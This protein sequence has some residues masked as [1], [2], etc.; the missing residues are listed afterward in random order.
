[1]KT[2]LVRLIIVLSLLLAN[3]VL[4]QT[5]IP[6]IAETCDHLAAEKIKNSYAE[7]VEAKRLE[8]F[9]TIKKDCI[10]RTENLT[11]MLKRETERAA[12]PKTK[13][14][15]AKGA[16]FVPGAIICQDYETVQLMYDWYVRVF[17]EQL[18]DTVTKGQSRL[19]LRSTPDPS[20]YLQ[21]FGCGWVPDGTPMT[22]ENAGED[23]YMPIVTARQPGKPPVRGVTDKAMIK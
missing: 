14:V 22:L 4:S 11:I 2:I 18:M 7:L 3:E 8:L 12:R 17:R 5:Q 13:A 10:A 1:M 21:R 16:G 9:E 20:S 6:T 15:T 23:T 19:A